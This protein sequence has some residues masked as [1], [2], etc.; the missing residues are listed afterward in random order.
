MQSAIARC[1]ERI[2]ISRGALRQC[3][4]GVAEELLERRCVVQ[5]ANL[6]APLG[7]LNCTFLVASVQQ[8]AREPIFGSLYFKPRARLFP[9]LQAALGGGDHS[10]RFGGVTV[11][12]LFERGS[13]VIATNRERP[14]ACGPRRQTSTRE[15]KG[16]GI[17]GDGLLEL[18]ATCECRRSRS[19][20]VRSWPS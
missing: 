17:R 18:V 6:D 8:T 4:S 15:L 13:Q 19:V 14:D 10:L 11:L 5:F 9:I 7:T 3:K 16:L 1:L 2:A 12:L 20:S